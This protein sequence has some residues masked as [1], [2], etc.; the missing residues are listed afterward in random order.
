MI[1]RYYY[2]IKKTIVKFLTDK[3]SLNW[4]LENQESN[5]SVDD[6]ASCPLTDHEVS[7]IQQMEYDILRNI[8]GI[9]LVMPKLGK[10]GEYSN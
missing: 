3:L 9:Y 5:D 1:Q 6:D 2:Y 4:K 10:L 8:E 7:A